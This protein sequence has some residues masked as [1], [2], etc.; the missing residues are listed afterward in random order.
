MT[1]QPKSPPE[2]GTVVRDWIPVAEPSIG[3]LEVSYV[4]DA[5]R[6]GWVSSIGPYVDA[7]EERI[8]QTCGARHAVSLCNGT[9]ALHLALVALG[10]G[11]GD[12]VVVPSLTFVATANAVRYVGAN[13]VFADCDPGTWCLTPDELAR[14]LT[15]R[16]KAVIPVDLFGQPYDVD[17]L[18]AVVGESSV[19]IVE[20]AAE[21]LGAS[22]HG[23]LAGTLGD[24][25]V[26]S[27]YGNKLVTSGEGGALVTDD[28]AIAERV[29]FLR[30]HAMSSQ[31]RYW[32]S[33]V[34]FNYRL[35]NIQAALGVAQLERFE[36]FAN[37]KRKIAARYAALLADVDAAQ[38]QI[39]PA[40]TRS[41]CW[42]FTV[43]LDERLNRDDVAD[44]LRKR[45]IDTRPAFVPLHLMPAHARE[46][47]L[48][49]SERVGMS[50]LTLPSG[51]TLSEAEQR[52]VVAALI[53]VIDG[54]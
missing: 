45:G 46:I 47:S 20:D 29:R 38:L 42:M 54:Q 28:G 11:P 1:L 39:E 8:A 24:V 4:T 43:V 23:R 22:Y 17:A 25:A 18:R 10:V 50:G 13:P 33:E 2:N 31:R 40:G 49:V 3:E 16:T 26:F 12:D 41:S 52:H 7:F 53:E 6:S 37:A 48:P 21:A 32:H 27:F 9:A 30:D 19:A 36:E 5:V 15:K 44:A 51:V 35:T 34:G 14:V